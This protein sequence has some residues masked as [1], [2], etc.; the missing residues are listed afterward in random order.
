MLSMGKHGPSS[1]IVAYQATT[2]A[3]MLIIISKYY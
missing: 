1:N 2:P 3:S